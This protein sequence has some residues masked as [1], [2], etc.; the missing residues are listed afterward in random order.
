MEVITEIEQEPKSRIYIREWKR[1]NYIK[2]GEDMKA[3]Q[4]A[5]YYKYKYGLSDEDMRKYKHMLPLV[6]KVSK[7]LEELKMANPEFFKE[8]LQKF[9]DEV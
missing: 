1:Q 9:I 3:S 6:S 2:N 7:N 8:I 4:R 5:Y